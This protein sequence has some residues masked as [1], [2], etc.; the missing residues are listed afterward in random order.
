[1]TILNL[2][3]RSQFSTLFPISPLSLYSL[4]QKEN[5]EEENIS[6]LIRTAAYLSIRKIRKASLKLIPDP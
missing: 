3:L 2:A 1:M 4:L 6:S 5:Q